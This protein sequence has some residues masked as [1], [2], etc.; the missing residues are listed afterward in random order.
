MT[1]ANVDLVTGIYAAYASGDREAVERAF[2]PD[3]R[4][5]NSGDDPTAGT[6]EG[7]AAVMDHLLGENH[8]EDYALDVDDVLASADRVAVV[9]RT[10][11]RRGDRWIENPFVQLVLVRDGRV[12]EVWNYYWDQRALAEFMR[13]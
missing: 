11:G 13:A 2:A 8:M 10:R 5:H 7:V 6:I 3:V 9:A 1:T 12:A 4:W